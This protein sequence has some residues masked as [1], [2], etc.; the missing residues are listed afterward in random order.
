MKFTI[1]E[2]AS[3]LLLAHRAVSAFGDV[4]LD[5]VCSRLPSHCRL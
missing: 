4:W 5:P 3:V 1:P 2:L